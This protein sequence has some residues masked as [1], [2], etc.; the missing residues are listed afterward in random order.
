MKLG[1]ERHF[2]L[3]TRK[4]D[5]AVDG[6]VKVRGWY[7]VYL[8]EYGE[9]RWLF[10]GTRQQLTRLFGSVVGRLRRMKELRHG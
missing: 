9:R 7:S 10:N 1:G 6:G 3:E 8:V 5:V 2:H 4:A